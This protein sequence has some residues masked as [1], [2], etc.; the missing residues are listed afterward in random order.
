MKRWQWMTCLM[1]DL[2]QWK[3][4][5]TLCKCWKREWQWPRIGEQWN[6]GLWRN[7]WLRQRPTSISKMKTDLCILTLSF[8]NKGNT[9]PA[10]SFLEVLRAS[11]LWLKRDTHQNTQSMGNPQLWM[12]IS[13]QIA[14]ESDT[15]KQEQSLPRLS[16]T[17]RSQMWVFSVD[18]WA[19]QTQLCTQ[20]SHP[21]SPEE[22]TGGHGQW[23]DEPG[24][25]AENR[26]RIS[27]S[28]KHC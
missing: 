17:S 11:R 7:R 25:K 6:G 18:P 9:L 13:T 22:T 15:H 20:D 21:K 5:L 14:V 3:H 27:I 26:R 24:E 10:L 23:Q 2:G 16:Q 12:W 28:L 19:P 8:L 1:A 4:N